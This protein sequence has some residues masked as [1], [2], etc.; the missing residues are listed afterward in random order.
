[1]GADVLQWGIVEW[2]LVFSGICWVFVFGGLA[3]AV[4][5]ILKPNPDDL[6]GLKAIDRLYVEW[7]AFRNPP[8]RRV[9]INKIKLHRLRQKAIERLTEEF[10]KVGSFVN[11]FRDKMVS[12]RSF[13]PTMERLMAERGAFCAG[14]GTYF[15]NPEVFYFA[16]HRNSHKTS[17]SNVPSY[18]A[19]R[20]YYI[21]FN[22]HDTSADPDI[23]TLESLDWDMPDVIG[24]MFYQKKNMLPLT[25][26]MFCRI[27]VVSSSKS[28]IE[29]M[30]N[31]AILKKLNISDSEV[32]VKLTVRMDVV[33]G[34]RTEEGVMRIVDM[35]R[36][37]REVIVKIEK[38]GVMRKR[39]ITENMLA[40]DMPM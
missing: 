17:P 35:D 29:N 21:V 5:I 12:D 15:K 23:R 18:Y 7:K 22:I 30:E 24:T 3:F 19:E 34:Y 11:V 10:K 8:R 33:H 13:G 38:D 31:K 6:I 36:H 37:A 16:E 27:K 25:E 4:M 40:W 28:D 14:C 39:V 9:L 20:D 2:A 32:F 1:M 26:P